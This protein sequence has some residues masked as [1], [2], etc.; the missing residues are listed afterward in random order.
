MV[1]PLLDAMGV[2]PV[3]L[4]LAIKRSGKRGAK[5][6]YPTDLRRVNLILEVCHDVTGRMIET[7][8]ENGDIAKA[9]ERL[10]QLWTE[11]DFICTLQENFTVL[12]R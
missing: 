12:G 11:E 4:L 1:S 8:V 2:I 3:Q 7:T 5:A 10:R 6:H 9:I